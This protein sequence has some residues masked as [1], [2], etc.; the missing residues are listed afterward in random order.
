METQIFH[1]AKI[2]SS[3]KP[4]KR[5]QNRSRRYNS[6]TK[7]KFQQKPKYHISKILI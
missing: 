6:I 5:N 4:S 7:L 3:N 2:Q 1:H